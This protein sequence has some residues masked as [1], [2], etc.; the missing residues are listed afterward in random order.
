MQA[1]H[2]LPQA[3][4][5]VSDAFENAALQRG[6]G[7]VYV[8]NDNGGVGWTF[9]R[10]NKWPGMLSVDVKE[11]GVSRERVDLPEL[12]ASSAINV[13]LGAS[14]VTDM[15]L[16]TLA[17]E[18]LGLDL[19]PTRRV[20]VRAAWYSLG[21]LL[22]EAAVRLLDV[23]SR[24]LRVGLYYEP[25]ADE[26]V[27]AWVYLA[28]TLENGAGYATYLG[29]A[30][31]FA[32]LM[33]DADSVVTDFE[34]PKHRDAC[35]S[36]CY[37]C[38]RDYYNMAYHPLLDWRLA[39]DL[40]EMLQGRG[41]D[42]APW[43]PIERSLADSFAI[44]LGLNPEQAIVDDLDGAVTGIRTGADLILVVHPLES[45]RVETF[46]T[47]RIARAVADAEDR[48]YDLGST[49]RLHDTFELLRLASRLASR[50]HAGA[51]Q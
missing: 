9:A 4:S 18:P 16:T 26:M 43:L 5:C 28:D 31:A 40:V 29:R 42:V 23:Q 6:R 15:M 22:R 24:E 12:D 13:A 17:S 11:G 41:F 3:R 30:E 36:S 37:D 32:R 45:Q 7:R 1:E 14:Y 10:A 39:R 49:L 20:G 44:A 21:F 38:L 48:G 46:T 51:L 50:Y 34:G 35:D 2:V 47:D 8:V 27:R 33:A 19:D 25:V